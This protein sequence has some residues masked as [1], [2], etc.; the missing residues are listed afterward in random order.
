MNDTQILSVLAQIGQ[1]LVIL[2]ILFAVLYTVVDIAL[3]IK[4]G[5]RPR[6]K[7]NYPHPPTI[8]TEAKYPDSPP[9]KEPVKLF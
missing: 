4:R 2:F 6:I 9:K 5:S 3:L 1:I 7:Q 8:Q